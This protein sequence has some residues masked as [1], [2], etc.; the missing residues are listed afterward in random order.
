[1]ANSID[2]VNFKE[3]P[4]VGR[5]NKE[6]DILPDQRFRLYN[7]QNGRVGLRLRYNTYMDTWF[8][9]LEVDN[10][11]ILYGRRIILN[12]DLLYSF[13]LD[14]GKLYALDIQGIRNGELTNE[15]VT[16]FDL[17]DGKIKLYFVSDDAFDVGID[18]VG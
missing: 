18:A 9:D 11:Y 4:I 6:K 7:I 15:N 14:I 10:E 3:I 8:F 13:G 17:P 5:Y 1:M 12:M 16:K 2:L